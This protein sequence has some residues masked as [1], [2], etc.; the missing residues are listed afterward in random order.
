MDKDKIFRRRWMALVSTGV[1]TSV[2]GCS[3][4]EDETDDGSGQT[5]DSAADTD[6]DSSDDGEG[7]TTTVEAGDSI[8]EAL[9]EVSEGGTV[10]LEPGE[11]E[12]AVLVDKSVTIEAPE[13]A[14]LVGSAIE[15]DELGG[16]GVP[17]SLTGFQVE[18]SEVEISGIE[19]LG[20]HTAITA[21][22]ENPVDGVR[23]AD[24]DIFESDAAVDGVFE[25]ITL[26]TITVEGSSET[27][28][29]I[30]LGRTGVLTIED[31]FFED[32]DGGLV[33]QGGEDI[34]IQGVELINN[35]GGSGLSLAAGDARGRK[36]EISDSDFLSGGGIDISETGGDEEVTLTNVTAEDNGSGLSVD[37]KDITIENSFFGNISR[38]TSANVLLQA[39]SDGEVTVRDTTVEEAEA[40]AG[41]GPNGNGLWVQ[42]GSH[43][44]I[45]DVKSSNNGGGNIVVSGNGT[46]DQTV[47]ILD[48]ESL[49]SGGTGIL[50]SGSDG[51]DSVTITD[52]VI[53]GA[54]D[55][56]VTVSGQEVTIEGTELGEASG[57][58]IEANLSI[59]LGADGIG[60]IK[61]TTVG[62]AREAAGLGPNGH[63]I[64][65]SGGS[66]LTIENVHADSDLSLTTL[67]R[68]E[69]TIMESTFN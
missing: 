15:S 42:G 58:P 37:S 69:I 39:D 51:D 61:D 28:V 45:D 17:E 5:E 11:Y 34:T 14:T 13:G 36:V 10:E 63:A 54:G 33:V 3:A 47:E 56:S 46:R 67:D 29:S 41:L 49:S 22:S 16:E 48:T 26:E 60:T 55:N 12:E 20:Y 8:V 57:P 30:E 27:P 65:V 32:N 66:D 53:D 31:G 7:E 35:H 6:E 38:Q 2:A 23:L 52:T 9:D 40:A 44:T 4:L 1:L 62:D 25:E 43:V 24:L 68:D 19:F 50:V 64:K 21:P 18:A 59:D